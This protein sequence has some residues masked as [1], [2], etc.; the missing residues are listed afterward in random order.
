MYKTDKLKVVTPFGG[1]K[2]RKLRQADTSA[3]VNDAFA[4]TYET[5]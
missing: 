2:L 5:S 4:N 1:K 3:E